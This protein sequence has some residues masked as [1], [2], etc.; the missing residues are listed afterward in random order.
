MNNESRWKEGTEAQQSE[1]G[2]ASLIGGVIWHSFATMQ[3]RHRDY[4]LMA[5]L[6]IAGFGALYLAMPDRSATAVTPT[7]DYSSYK[8]GANCARQDGYEWAEDR[9]LVDLLDCPDEPPA[10]EAGCLASV[11]KREEH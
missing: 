3:K 7:V 2:G 9:G 11:S 6:S 10:F 5:G 8:C 1:M 4:M